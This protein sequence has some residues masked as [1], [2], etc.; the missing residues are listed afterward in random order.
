[1]SIHTGLAWARRTR[2]PT[3]HGVFAV[4]AL[5]L[6]LASSPQRALAQAAG[7]AADTTVAVTLLQRLRDG[8][9]QSS[10]AVTAARAELE[11]ARARS[12]AAGFAA[13]AYLSAGISEAP[14]ANLDQG[15]IRLEVG[16]TLFTGARR[17][18]ER[19]LAEAEVRGA[20]VVLA[21]AERR[22]DAVVRRELIRA[23]G[24]QLV[25]N[26]LASED[27]LLTS[28]EEGLR[29]RFTVGDARYTD[30]L[31]L[32]TERLRVQSERAAAIAEA[33]GARVALGGLVGDSLRGDFQP[34]VDAL[35][36]T[37]FAAAW[38]S[39]LPEADVLDSLVA[40]TGDVQQSEVAVAR[41]RAAQALTAAE[42]RPLVDASA[43]IQRIGQAND[44]PALG[45]SVGVTVSLPF[46]AARANRL[47]AQAAASEVVAAESGRRATLAT[48]RARVAAAA[49]RYAAARQR[50]E[51]FD[52][53]LLR[54]ARDERE[55]ALASYRTR[56]V[57][58]LELIDF[59]RALA[60]A[61]IDRI[62]ALIDAADAWA[63]LVTGG[64]ADEGITTI[65]A[66][67][68]R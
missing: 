16:R 13:P 41:A 8:A 20:E 19:T 61:E 4:A 59:E 39:L 50:L 2:G 42:R 11:A 54:G 24:E 38:R 21:A 26:R 55:A 10:P 12:R 45:P 37:D 27:A 32:R 14:N 5:A 15:N 49:E 43:G 7:V 1:M 66:H 64:A 60:R 56:G 57:S 33:R 67:E 17:R 46:T 18:A 28:A 65:S 36:A 51:V 9:R 40:A 6:S 44:G 23:A 30:V 53:A 22:V 35:A 68:G 25:A 48:V 31:R 58:L 52:A 62:E 29:T 47:G 34:A 3:G 63:D